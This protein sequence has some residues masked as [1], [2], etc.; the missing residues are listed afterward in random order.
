MQLSVV[1][2]RF[3]LAGLWRSLNAGRLLSLPGLGYWVLGI[4]Y[5]RLLRWQVFLLLSAGRLPSL[6]GLRDKAFRL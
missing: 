3:P 6:P 1:S 2:C 5:I 4:R